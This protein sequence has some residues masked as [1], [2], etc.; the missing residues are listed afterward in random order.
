MELDAPHGRAQAV[1]RV[2]AGGAGEEGD[3]AFGP[4]GRLLPVVMPLISG[5]SM[6]P[7]LVTPPAQVMRPAGG[8]SHADSGGQAPRCGAT[9]KVL[10]RRAVPCCGFAGMARL[11]AWGGCCAG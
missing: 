4:D 10:G 8:E 5:L 3:G 7:E 11:I 9:K 2:G 6:P 1:G